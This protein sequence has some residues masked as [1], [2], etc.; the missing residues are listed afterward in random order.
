MAVAGGLVAGGAGDELA[1]G[2]GEG[3]APGVGVAVAVG[4]SVG[5]GG[6]VGR[7]TAPA[8]REVTEGV[9]DLVNFSVPEVA[10]M[11][12]AGTID[13]SRIAAAIMNATGSAG[14]R[15]LRFP[16]D[17]MPNLLYS[18]LH[19][20]GRDDFVSVTMKMASAM[21]GNRYIRSRVSL[22]A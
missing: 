15:D 5:A 1:V 20:L 13:P 21:F 19:R 7:A 18:P 4:A 10:V 17:S 2:V 8:S 22:V 9:S 12:Q 6:G 11:V 14:N 3:V 16:R